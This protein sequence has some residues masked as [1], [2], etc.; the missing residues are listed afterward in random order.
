MSRADP[1]GADG[2]AWGCDDEDDD[3]VEPRLTRGSLPGAVRSAFV[4][5]YYQSIRLVPANLVWG[6]V[7]IAL[8]WLAVSAGFWLAVLLAPLLGV[9]LVGIYRLAGLVTRSREVVFSDMG[10]AMREQLVPAL[11]AAAALRWGCGLL[12]FNIA[13]GLGAANPV[14]WALATLSGWG[15]VALVMYSVV[16]WPLLGDPARNEVPARDRARL[17]GYVVLAAPIRVAVLTAIA[18]VLGVISSI[19]FAAVVSITVAYV[20]LLSCRVV[21][22]DADTLAERLEARRG[23]GP[24]Q[25]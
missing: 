16:I 3:D 6:V 10:R 4:D 1:G 7:L 11:V 2:A 17:A 5:F 23:E 18:V 19:A 24:P 13:I 14:G 15:L 9:P 8:A 21:L 12:A 25:R 22:P 20:A